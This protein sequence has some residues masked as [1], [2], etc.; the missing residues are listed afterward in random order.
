MIQQTEAKQTETEKII[1]RKMRDL[2]PRYRR[3]LVKCSKYTGGGFGVL[4]GNK[5]DMALAKAAIAQILDD[6]TDTERNAIE[7]EMARA[8]FTHAGIG[9]GA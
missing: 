5:A 1:R 9:V 3:A 2:E 8:M 6:L 7:N 4:A